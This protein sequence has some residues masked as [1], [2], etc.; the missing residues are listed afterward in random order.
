[1]YQ[2]RYIYTYKEGNITAYYIIIKTITAPLHVKHSRK[3]PGSDGSEN[4]EK[5]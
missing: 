1:M 3:S 2:R 4:T 5:K